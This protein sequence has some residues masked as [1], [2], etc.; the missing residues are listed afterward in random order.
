MEKKNEEK[1]YQGQPLNEVPILDNADNL[2]LEKKKKELKELYGE[3]PGF[4]TD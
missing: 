4:F 2:L 1:E 3:E